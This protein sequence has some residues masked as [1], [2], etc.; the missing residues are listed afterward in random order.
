MILVQSREAKSMT[1]LDAEKIAILL[2]AIGAFIVA[3]IPSLIAWRTA[4]QAARRDEVQL[5]REEIERL[6]QRLDEQISENGAL[7]AMNC[8]LMKVNADLQVQVT[9]Q[10][11]SIKEL[12]ARLTEKD[13]EIAQLHEELDELRHETDT[14]GSPKRG[15]GV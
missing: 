14:L 11:E 4:R 13:Q 2:G 3:V 8:E 12:K 6:H 7:R 10:G 1:D 15:E 9:V 5:L